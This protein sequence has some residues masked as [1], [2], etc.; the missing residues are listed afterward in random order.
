MTEVCLM[1]SCTLALLLTWAVPY[2]NYKRGPRQYSYVKVW[3]P[4]IKKIII[5]TYNLL[6]FLSN[7]FILTL[8]YVTNQL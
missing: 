3:A 1:Q 8:G 6:S 7:N 4:L 2:A 5:S